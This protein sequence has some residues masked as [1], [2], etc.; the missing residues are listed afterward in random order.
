MA[1][2]QMPSWPGGC[3][4]GS[5]SRIMMM[6]SCFSTE[7]GSR[8]LADG[9][10]VVLNPFGI[11]FNP[12]SIASSIVRLE[13]GTPFTEGDVIER[14]GSFVSF[15]HHGSFRRATPDEFLD[16]ANASLARS[17][18]D[19]NN[20]DTVILTFGTAWVFR[21]LERDIIVSNCHKVP[22]REFRRERLSVQDMVGMISPI[23]ARHTDKHWIFTVSPIRH[24]ADGAH[25]NQLSKSTLLL[26]IDEV[27]RRHPD[28]TAYFPAFEM[29]VDELR[30][31]S[32]YNTANLTHPSEEAV[33]EIYRRF[34]EKSR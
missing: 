17:M 34:T 9:Y 28:V 26:A 6:G 3:F 4:V 8:L 19:F 15:F 25:G 5:D 1:E 21:H 31:Y 27:C 33:D 18:E 23:V 11:L 24:M 32:W 16:N 14:E 30:D 29:M 2:P 13:N 10:H 20:A 7:V 22:A 12:A